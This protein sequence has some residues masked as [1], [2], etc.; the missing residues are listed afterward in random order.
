M[1]LNPTFLI[2][3]I[4][5]ATLTLLLKILFNIY[6]SKKLKKETDFEFKNIS[7]NATSKGDYQNF[8]FSIDW[9]NIYLKNDSI[10]LVPK[11]TINPFGGSILSNKLYFGEKETVIMDKIYMNKFNDLII[12]Y[13]AQDGLSYIIW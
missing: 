13:Y 1:F 9:Y 5:V 8:S 12:E 4:S 3:I 6:Y 10:Y 7:G 11:I 2:F